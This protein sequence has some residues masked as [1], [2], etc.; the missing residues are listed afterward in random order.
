MILIFD[1][2]FCRSADGKASGSETA[3]IV[4]GHKSIGAVSG[5]DH[6][7]SELGALWFTFAQA[8]QVMVLIPWGSLARRPPQSAQKSRVPTRDMV[9]VWVVVWRTMV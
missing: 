5:E 3:L 1:L 2:R 4:L 8:A 6:G 7:V 9:V